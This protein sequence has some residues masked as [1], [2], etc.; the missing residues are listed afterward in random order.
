MHEARHGVECCALFW[1]LEGMAQS[2]T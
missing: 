1:G 2:Y